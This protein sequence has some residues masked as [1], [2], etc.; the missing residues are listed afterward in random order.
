MSEEEER[1]N[2]IPIRM[3]IDASNFHRE[4]KYIEET[5][6][7]FQELT[8]EFSMAGQ[9][10]VDQVTDAL[11]DQ[12]QRMTRLLNPKATPQKITYLIK[13]VNSL[14]ETK[15]MLI[16][17]IKQLEKKVSEKNESSTIV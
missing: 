5:L 4:L 9:N 8:R 10:V 6:E 16:K 13:Q 7:R 1:T 14:E 15:T 11:N 12:T 3:M 17:E 2:L